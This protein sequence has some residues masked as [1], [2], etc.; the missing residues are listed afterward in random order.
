MR[1]IVVL[2]VVTYFASSIIGIYWT[3]TYYGEANAHFMHVW[4]IQ[5]ILSVYSFTFL[6][7]SH[8]LKQRVKPDTKNDFVEPLAYTLFF[9]FFISSYSLNFLLPSYFLSIALPLNFFS[10]FFL[11]DVYQT[12]DYY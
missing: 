3:L 1:P 4:R 2:V 10:I 7:L 11:T 5:A 8:L 9:L 6:L 12:A